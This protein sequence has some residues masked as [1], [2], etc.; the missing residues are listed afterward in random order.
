M[1]TRNVLPS[2]IATL[3]L[4]APLPNAV[5][6]DTPSPDRKKPQTELLTDFRPIGGLGNNIVDP[7]INAVPGIPQIALTPLNFAPGTNNVVI[8]APNARLI[9][10]VIGGG[11]GA[12][13]EN[14]D[15]EDPLASAWLYVFGQFVDH[16]IDLEETLPT[17][18]PIDIVIP[19]GDPTFPEGTTIAMTRPTRNPATNTIVNTV[20]GYLDLSQ[21]YGSTQAIADSLTNPDGSLASSHKGRQLPLVNDTFITGDPR[22]MEN[23]ELTAVTTLFMSTTPGSKH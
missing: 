21:L 15:T 19:P 23:P 8:A 14:A 22:V 6:Q 2:C 10:N 7:G 5:A 16:D 1:S 20:A 13:G 3:L 18:S 9:S 4:F 12:N 11:T 17:S